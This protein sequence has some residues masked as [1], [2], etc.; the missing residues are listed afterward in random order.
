MNMRN[1][2]IYTNTQRKK[3]TKSKEFIQNGATAKELKFCHGNS[4]LISEWPE[5]F[6]LTKKLQ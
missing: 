6:E 4:A 2:E 3:L 5:W 1:Y